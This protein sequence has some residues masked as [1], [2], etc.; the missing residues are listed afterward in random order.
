MPFS[1]RRRR[2]APTS[3]LVIA[4]RGTFRVPWSSVRTWRNASSTPIT[5]PS[6][7]P[8][9]GAR[10]RTFEPTVSAGSAGGCA[11]SSPRAAPARESTD[12][13]RAPRNHRRTRSESAS[14]ERM[15]MQETR[16][17]AG[18]CRGKS[19]TFL[20]KLVEGSNVVASGG[21]FGRA[22]A[23]MRRRDPSKSGALGPGVRAPALGHGA[24]P[25]LGE[26]HGRLL[27]R[28]RQGAERIFDGRR[29]PSSV[30]WTHS[31]GNVSTRAWGERP[32][33]SSQR[34]IGRRQCGP[35]STHETTAWRLDRA[36]EELRAPGCVSTSRASRA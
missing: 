14:G 4:S 27:V 11:R 33:A 16:T 35:T 8:T 28:E 24:D 9:A 36:D 34:N 12:P 15:F 7:R 29:Q 2:P 5:M 25:L 10:R 32:R 20:E 23:P 31:P 30:P 22:R 3:I 17:T 19:A 18:I 1:V 6:M 21:R 13:T 26:R